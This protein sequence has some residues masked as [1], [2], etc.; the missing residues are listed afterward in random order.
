MTLL[1]L[2]EIDISDK[3]EKYYGNYSYKKPTINRNITFERP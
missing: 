2:W 1:G 3:K